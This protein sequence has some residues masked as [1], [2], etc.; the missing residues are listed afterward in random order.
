M[1]E[2]TRV[3]TLLINAAKRLFYD[4]GIGATGIDAI[5][6]IAGVAKMS[7]YNNFSSKEELINE[8]VE[9]CY[10][11]WFVLYKTY[12]SVAETRQD[13]I[14]AIFDAHI[15]NFD[16]SYKGR[17]RGC[18]LLNA[19][20]ELQLGSAVRRRIAARKKQ[21][22]TFIRQHLSEGQPMN[23]IAKDVLTQHVAFLL[24]GALCKC[25]LEGSVLPLL[26]ARDIARTIIANF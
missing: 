17:I 25:G 2:R 26:S 6:K 3:R 14:L 18:P 11:E 15:E 22:E 12:L 9:E 24:E 4:H 13:K 10:G 21:T 16:L 20:G 1:N 8:F 7:L 5:V 19:A 23:D